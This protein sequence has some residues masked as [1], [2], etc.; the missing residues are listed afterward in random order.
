VSV[1]S[2]VY[3]ALAASGVGLYVED[4][5]SPTPYR[6]YPEVAPQSTLFPLVIY[7][8]VAQDPQRSVG[9]DSGIAR[10]VVQVDC[11]ALSLLTAVAMADA[12]KLAM[13]GNFSTF[14]GL[15]QDRRNDFDEEQR[16]FRVSQDF[17]VWA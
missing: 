9:G 4:V 17:A 6:I 7:R 13:F 14:N 10:T 15:A 5:G 11:Y 16:V 3:T 1:E 2:I 8:V 12:V